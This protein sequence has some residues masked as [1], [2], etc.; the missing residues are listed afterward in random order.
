MDRD[1]IFTNYVIAPSAAPAEPR[2]RARRRRSMRRRALPLAQRRP[3]PSRRAAK[4]K[5]KEKRIGPI[6]LRTIH[7]YIVIQHLSIDAGMPKT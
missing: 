5:R 7:P 3:R 1:Y 4:K 6:L 2:V